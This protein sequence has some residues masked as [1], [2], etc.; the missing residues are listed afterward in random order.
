MEIKII[1]AE[2]IRLDE[3]NQGIIILPYND[4]ADE[5]YTYN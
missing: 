5:K 1:E 3:E 4:E 2:D